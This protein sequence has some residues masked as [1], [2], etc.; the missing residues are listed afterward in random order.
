[1]RPK[2]SNAF[3]NWYYTHGRKQSPRTPEIASY[4]RCG[5]LFNRI[6]DKLDNENK[7]AIM[8]RITTVNAQAKAEKIALFN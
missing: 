7:E 6:Q 5:R 4:R 2:H 8:L 1:M 3:G